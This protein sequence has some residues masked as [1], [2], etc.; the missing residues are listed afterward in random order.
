MAGVYV[1]MARPEPVPEPTTATISDPSAAPGKV[2]VHVLG[3][4]NKPGIVTLPNG[5]RV[6]DAIQAA[7]GIR[8]GAQSGT[9][10]LAR[11]AQD[12]EQISVGLAAPQTAASPTAATIDLNTATVAQ[13]D[14]LPGVGP[15]LAQRIIDYRTQHGTFR[16]VDQLQEVSGIGARRFADLKSQVRV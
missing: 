16:S 9:L 1:W 14:A 4:V 11:K 12:G 8:A 7:G 2:T 6:A 10:N 3:K 5:S 15:V 13:L